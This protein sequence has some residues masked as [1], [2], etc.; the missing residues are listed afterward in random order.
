[1]AKLISK[2]V[3]KEGLSMETTYQCCNFSLII[4]IIMDLSSANPPTCGNFFVQVDTP[5]ETIRYIVVLNGEITVYSVD[6]P[7]GFEW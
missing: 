7:N 5:F 4:I 1:M 3:Q 6:S 2:I